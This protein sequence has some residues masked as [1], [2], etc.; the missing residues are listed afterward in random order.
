VTSPTDNAA[1]K[2][3]ANDSAD[4]ICA[5]LG[6]RD[7]ETVTAESELLSMPQLVSMV[8][9]D[10]IVFGQQ[11]IGTEPEV[12]ERDPEGLGV[13]AVSQQIAECKPESLCSLVSAVPNEAAV[14]QTAPEKPHSQTA[15]LQVCAGLGLSVRDEGEFDPSTRSAQQPQACDNETSARVKAVE[16][17]YTATPI[18]VCEAVEV[19]APAIGT[20]PVE[21]TAANMNFNDSGDNSDLIGGCKQEAVPTFTTEASPTT[22]GSS[23]SLEAAPPP[24]PPVVNDSPAPRSAGSGEQ[25]TDSYTDEGGSVTI[26][27]EVV[28]QCGL[29]D[30]QDPAQDSDK[31]QSPVDVADSSVQSLA[32]VTD[33]SIRSP[34]NV[35]DSAI[36]SPANVANSAIQSQAN[37]A[38]SSVQSPADMDDSSAQFPVRSPAD[39]AD[40]SVQS[41]AN[42]ADIESPASGNCMV[43]VSD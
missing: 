21:I 28:A 17:F 24:S 36:Q 40:S 23:H 42:V 30:G 8:S 25:Q 26:F 5:S 43:T 34:K 29:E 14:P 15:Q 18:S 2:Q 1:R 27:G 22:R 37:V 6:L 10:G 38:D 19:P 39:V 7:G 33:S 35:A 16:C 12:L 31:V 32:N 41:P 4:N 11:V 20:L 3:T 9:G 13:G